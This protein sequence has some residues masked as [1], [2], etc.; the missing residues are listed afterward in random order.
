[1]FEK[2]CKTTIWSVN[3]LLCEQENIAG[4]S[5]AGEEELDDGSWWLKCSV[6]SIKSTKKLTLEQSINKHIVQIK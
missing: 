3:Q 6:K 2:V 4:S 1:M 5:A